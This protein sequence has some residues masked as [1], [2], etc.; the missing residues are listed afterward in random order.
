M[1]IV[2]ICGIGDLSDLGKLLY[3]RLR[4][5]TVIFNLDDLLF[6]FKRDNGGFVENKYQEFIDNII[7]KYF[8]VRLLI[9]IGLNAS[10]QSDRLYDLQAT[11]KIFVDLPKEQILRQKFY[12]NVTKLAE[13]KKYYFDSNQDDLFD[14]IDI[15]KWTREIER[16]ENLYIKH[17][18]KFIKYEEIIDKII[19]F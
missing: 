17:G 9:F 6:I 14:M 1:P 12:K 15:K 18:Y 13:Q 19:R 10:Y 5:E 2:H 3:R 4:K 11:Y 8:D 7:H 16:Y